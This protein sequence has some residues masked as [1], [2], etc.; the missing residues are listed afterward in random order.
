MCANRMTAET[1]RTRPHPIRQPTFKPLITK[2][3]RRH[4]LWG[5]SG[6]TVW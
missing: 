5:A 3:A 6:G 1:V 2:K 4:A